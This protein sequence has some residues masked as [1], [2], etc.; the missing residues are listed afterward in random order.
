MADPREEYQS[1]ME[2]QRRLRH[3]HVEARSV[4]ERR[5]AANEDPTD[6]EEERYRDAQDALDGINLRINRFTE[7]QGTLGE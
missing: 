3:E 7:E 6:D 4:L 1:M 2:E 5:Q